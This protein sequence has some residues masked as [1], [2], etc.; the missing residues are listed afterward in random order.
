MS[1]LRAGMSSRYADDRTCPMCSGIMQ[2]IG[3]CR[4]GDGPVQGYS[5][6]CADCG[7]CDTVLT[8]YGVEVRKADAD[9]RRRE[10]D[11]YAD[12]VRK[13]VEERQWRGA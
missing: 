4:D 6:Q 12:E 9:L 5:F 11:A 8:P 10:L 3:D 2:C 7:S 13:A 1:A